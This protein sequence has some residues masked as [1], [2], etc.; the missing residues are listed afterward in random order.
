MRQYRGV[1][2]EHGYAVLV[3]DGTESCGL[4]PRFAL[5]CHSPEGFSWGYA[6][7]GPAQL[8]LAICADALGDDDRAQDLYQT[9][10]FRVIAHLPEGCWVL[11]EREVLEHLAAIERERAALLAD[12]GVIDS[13]PAPLSPVPPLARR[14][15][16][17][18]AELA[19]H[20]S[21]D[22]TERLAVMRER[23]WMEAVRHFVARGE[24]THAGQV[25]AGKLASTSEEWLREQRG[26]VSE[27]KG[28]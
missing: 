14:I 27:G 20:P 12:P 26:D 10:K 8:A 15:D 6:G 13:P 1:Q 24:L 9:F 3:E 19:A 28:R 7:S 23:G 11:S 5:R 22:A 25:E 18:L 17:H 21:D 2:T 16:R 4:D